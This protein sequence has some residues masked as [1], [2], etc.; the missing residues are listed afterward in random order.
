MGQTPTYHLPWPEETDPPDGPV[1]I[2]ALA[3]ATETAVAGVATAAGSG[4]T[5]AQNNPQV[6]TLSA[7]TADSAA[8]AGNNLASSFRFL[9]PR[10]LGA[11]FMTLGTGSFLFTR[12]GFYDVYARIRCRQSGAAAV[13]YVQLFTTGA[14]GARAQLVPWVD[15]WADPEIRF[16]VEITN[17]LVNSPSNFQV[18]S[19]TP[20]TFLILGTGTQS[21]LTV[22]RH[23]DL[24][25]LTSP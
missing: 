7:Q 1:Q 19:S 21:Q 16:T 13:G 23:G 14:V 12:S 18:A 11:P 8:L 15:V 4:A 20:G 6:P 22:I 2:R 17:P 3:Q 5:A 24:A 25:N 9:N 10:V